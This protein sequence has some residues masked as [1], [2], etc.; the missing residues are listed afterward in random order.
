MFRPF[1][2]EIAC[3]KCGGSL[4]LRSFRL[5][6][7]RCPKCGEKLESRVINRAFA[8]FNGLI[9]LALAAAVVCDSFGYP[10]VFFFAWLTISV[11]VWW[12]P[13]RWSDRAPTKSARAADF[14]K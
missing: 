11:L 7:T 14:K 10:L 8:K 9:L 5:A 2:N 4:Q 12:T 6:S 13:S 1:D 3:G